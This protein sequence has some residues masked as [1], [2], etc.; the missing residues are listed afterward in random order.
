[1]VAGFIAIIPM[2]L[3]FR[4]HPDLLS[5]RLPGQLLSVYPVITAATDSSVVP[6]DGFARLGLV[7]GEF[8]PY[9]CE[10]GYQGTIR[11]TGTDTTPVPV[12]GMPCAPSRRVRLPLEG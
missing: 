10:R 2:Y 1:V 7:L 4:D 3:R 5:L 6:D 12:N 8:D 11:W 9:T